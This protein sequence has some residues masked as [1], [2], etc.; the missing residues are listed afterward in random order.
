MVTA[1]AM[2]TGAYDSYDSALALIEAED[3]IVSW[4]DF[5]GAECDFDYVTYTVGDRETEATVITI[6][7][8]NEEW[9]VTL[10]VIGDE[11]SAF[12]LSV[13]SKDPGFADRI[14]DG[15]TIR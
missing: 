3:A 6:L 10:M 12:L 11:D 15:V 14:M 1:Q 9:Y 4:V 7:T 13:Y 2:H 5:G 8:G